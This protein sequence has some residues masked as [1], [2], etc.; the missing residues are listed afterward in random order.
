MTVPL[1]QANQHSHHLLMP[2]F[3]RLSFFTTGSLG[4][5]PLFTTGLLGCFPFFTTDPLSRCQVLPTDPFGF[6]PVAAAVSSVK[7]VGQQLRNSQDGQHN[8]DVGCA[9]KV[10]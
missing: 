8:G 1:Q 2:P 10:L 9:L 7:I 4:H 5:L 3:R 6:R